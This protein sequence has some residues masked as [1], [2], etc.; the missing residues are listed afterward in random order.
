MFLSCF[1][2]SDASQSSPRSRKSLSPNSKAALKSVAPRL[3]SFFFRFRTMGWSWKPRVQ[4]KVRTGQTAG[5]PGPRGSG[6][7][8]LS[9][10]QTFPSEPASRTHLMLGL[11]VGFFRTLVLV[12]DR[13]DQTQLLQHGGLSGPALEQLRRVLDRSVDS[14]C[15]CVGGHGHTHTHTH[16]SSSFFL[17]PG[18]RQLVSGFWAHYRHLVL[19]SVDR[20]RFTWTVDS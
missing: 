3:P 17:L 10:S 19:W 20:S 13:S 8:S 12:P 5:P 6:P 2:T 15:T 16:A 1:I 11:G 9:R 14:S 7:R 4:L 18:Q